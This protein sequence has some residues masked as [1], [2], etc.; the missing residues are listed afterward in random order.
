MK[1][2]ESGTEYTTL[3]LSVKGF[4]DDKGYETYFITA[5]RSEVVRSAQAKTDGQAKEQETVNEK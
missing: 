2:S 5:Y 1:K 4:G 3:A